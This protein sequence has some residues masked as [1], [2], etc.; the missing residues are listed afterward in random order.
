MWLDEVEFGLRMW[1]G[2][3]WFCSFELVQGV[4]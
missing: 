1:L 2:G 3:L 4:D